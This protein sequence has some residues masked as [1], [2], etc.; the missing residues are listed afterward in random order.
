MIIIFIVIIFIIIFI[1]KKCNHLNSRVNAV[2]TQNNM[3][4]I[5]A[6]MK[7]ISNTN[8]KLYPKK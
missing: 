2:S 7:S 6:S 3:C 1:G 8:Q 5:S 4:A